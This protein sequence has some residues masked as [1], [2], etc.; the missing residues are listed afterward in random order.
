MPEYPPLIEPPM[1]SPDATAWARSF[2]THAARHPEIVR[3]IDTITT[4]FANAMLANLADSRSEVALLAD[5]NLL[6]A[7]MSDAKRSLR[8]AS[9]ALGH[10]LDLDESG[11]TPAEKRTFSEAWDARVDARKAT[12]DD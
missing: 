10:V 9:R 4:W 11:M 6:R 1:G 3:S 7:R 5:N 8:A 2:V 12:S